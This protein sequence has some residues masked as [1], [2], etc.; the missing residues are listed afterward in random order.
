[1]QGKAFRIICRVAIMSA[2]T[3]LTLL[4][5]ADRNTTDAGNSRFNADYFSNDTV[6]DQQGMKLRFFEDLIS[7][8]IVIINFVYL[9]CND[10]CPLTT[11]R[12]AELVDQLGDIVGDK[13]HVY[14]ITMDPDRDRPENLKAYAS[15]FDAGNGWRFLTGDPENIKTIRW[16]L[17]ERSRTLAEHRN[18]IV[19]GNDVTGEWSRI[20][21]YSDIEILKRNVR[22]VAGLPEIDNPGKNISGQKS[23][24]EGAKLSRYRLDRMVGEALFIKACSTCHSIGRGDLVGPDLK[25]IAIRRTKDWLVKFIMNPQ[26][27]LSQKDPLTIEISSR[28]PGVSMPNLGLQPNDVDDLLSYISQRSAADNVASSKKNNPETTDQNKQ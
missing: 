13:V 14:T 23:T 16:R 18:D 3:L 21:A 19:L 8:K 26:Q 2:L 7:G 20:S 6:I 15:A 25:D 12:I 17:G 1:V 28:Y 9:N 4:V 5:A 11:S 22:Q 24:P 10:L 27:M